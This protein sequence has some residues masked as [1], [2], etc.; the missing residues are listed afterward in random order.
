MEVSKVTFTDE[1]LQKTKHKKLSPQ[2]KGRL[3]WERL[4]K[5]D[6]NGA[7]QNVKTRLELGHLV[8]IPADRNAYAWVTQMVARGVVTE[9]VRGFENNRAMYEYH[10]GKPLNYSAGRKPKKE[11]SKQEMVLETIEEPVIKEQPR[12]PGLEL[13]TVVISVNGSELRIENA[14]AKFVVELM[15]E[16]KK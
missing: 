12:V 4:Q 8:G 3:R 7:L 9:T 2:E 10:I 16:L 15:R 5:A 11:A 1:F 14:S 6:A 13:A